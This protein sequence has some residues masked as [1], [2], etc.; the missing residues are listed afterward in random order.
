MCILSAFG[1][2]GQRCSALRMLFVPQ[3]DRR[4]PDRGPG[5]R[6]DALVL[7]DPAD[8]AT[9]IGPVIDEEA[10]A[11][12]EAHVAPA[13]NAR[14][15]C[16]HRLDPGALRPGA[17]SSARSSPRSRRPTSCE[18]EVFGPILHVYRY[19]PAELA[20]AAA[21]L[22]ARGYGL[23]LG[24]HSRI[25]AFA[26]RGAARWSR[27]ATSTSTA[28]S[29][30]RWSASSPSAARA[31]PAPAPRPA[32]PTPCSATPLERARQRQH[33]RPGRRPGAA[34]SVSPQGI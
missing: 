8:P 18:R 33:R 25:E 20:D 27:P 11:A 3:R 2:A 23:T 19:D 34:Q 7:G 13:A 5:R 30:A 1:S 26:E 21:P 31:C 28:R 24:V 32:A 9:D 16:S 15:R 14:R 29:S 4:R 6:L 12:L 17:A 10:R 22:A